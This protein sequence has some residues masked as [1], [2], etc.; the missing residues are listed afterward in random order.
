MQFWF[1]PRPALH[2]SLSLSCKGMDEDEVHKAFV[3][4]KKQQ[5]LTLEAEKRSKKK[6]N[7]QAIESES[8]MDISSG[9]QTKLPT[10]EPEVHEVLDRSLKRPREGTPTDGA[11][12]MTVDATTVE[13]GINISNSITSFSIQALASLGSEKKSSLCSEQVIAML[14]QAMTWE[15][16]HSS[17]SKLDEDTIERLEK[18]TDA[19]EDRATAMQQKWKSIEEELKK[20]LDREKKLHEELITA[21]YRAFKAEVT[22]YEWGLNNRMKMVAEAGLDYSKV[23]LEDEIDIWVDIYHKATGLTPEKYKKDPKSHPDYD[24]PLYPDDQE[25]GDENHA[26]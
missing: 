13:W 20:A 21:N 1:Q 6:N 18:S 9:K 24:G 26:T 25:E 17:S 22:H 2:N 8:N 16:A 10:I 11:S 12:F 5:K 23:L 19:A 15:K 3:A 7:V 14:S 4:K